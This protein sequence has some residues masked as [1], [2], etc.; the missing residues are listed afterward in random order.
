[1]SDNIM[2]SLICLSNDSPLPDIISLCWRS[3]ISSVSMTNR[4]LRAIV[5]EEMI[6]KRRKRL[7]LVEHWFFVFV[8]SGVWCAFDPYNRA[9]HNVPLMP[10]PPTWFRYTGVSPPQVIMCVGSELLSCAKSPVDTMHKFQALTGTWSLVAGMTNQPA[11]G[12]AWAVHEDKIFA[13]GGC[14]ADRKPLPSAHMYNSET[15]LWTSI[16]PMTHARMCCKGA[17][18]D[19]KFFVVGGKLSHDKLET[20]IAE[21]YDPNSKTWSLIHDFLTE[22][23]VTHSYV[24]TVVN[25]EMYH[26]SPS[27]DFG[28]VHK[29]SPSS[30]E[31]LFMGCFPWDSLPKTEAYHM[32]AYRPVRENPFEHLVLMLWRMEKSELKMYIDVYASAPKPMLNW[33]LLTSESRDF[34]KFSQRL[35]GVMGY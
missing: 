24:I 33:I 11:F 19:G 13:A 14:D 23:M 18:M 20:T 6:I 9:W 34:G 8:E 35:G 15:G 30:G 22:D 28:I 2:T 32:A 1:M 16:P 3:D 17:F 26:A 7:G 29:Y 10:E 21:V 4:R 31:W 25:K 27:G 5:R 12:H